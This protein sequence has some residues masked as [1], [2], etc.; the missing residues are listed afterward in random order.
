[1]IKKQVNRPAFLFKVLEN[2]QQL[3]SASPLGNICNC[4]WFILQTMTTVGLGDYVPETLIARIMA[5]IV[6]VV[7]LLLQSLLMVSITLFI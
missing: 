7:G 4:Y 5:V 6:S 2:Y 3:E 1:M